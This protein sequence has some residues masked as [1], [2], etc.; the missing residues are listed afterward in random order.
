MD[1][2]NGF[3]IMEFPKCKM[4]TSGY[5]KM[6]DNPFAENGKMK[7]FEEWWAEYDKKRTDRWFM[8]DFVM[9]GREGEN[10]IIWFYAVPDDAVINCEYEVID[11]EGGIYASGVAICDNREDESRV[12]RAIK[13]WV[14]KS[15]VFELDERPG[16][17]DISH[18]LAPN[19]Q[20]TMGY[21]Q[22]EIYVPIKLRVN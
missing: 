10:E 8:R 7:L 11:F 17:Y 12:Y 18:G 1:N 22:L 5:C 13:E 9:R 14:K 2:I 21:L 4:V 3:R 15:G 19:L 16:H 6:E 20:K